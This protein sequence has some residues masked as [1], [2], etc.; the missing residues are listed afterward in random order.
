MVFTLAHFVL[1]HSPA[2]SMEC[3]VLHTHLTL[4]CFIPDWTQYTEYCICDD[5][6]SFESKDMN[7]CMYFLVLGRRTVDTVHSL[8][9]FSEM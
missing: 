2:G 5:I 6:A 1:T 3:S 4:Q 9:R 7:V 8:G